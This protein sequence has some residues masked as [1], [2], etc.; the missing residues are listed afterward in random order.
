[1][2]LGRIQPG[3]DAVPARTQAL[4]LIGRLGV[5]VVIA[6]ATND[7]G[8]IDLGPAGAIRVIRNPTF[9][10]VR[11]GG[12]GSGRW[13]LV[14]GRWVDRNPF[15]SIDLPPTSIDPVKRRRDTAPGC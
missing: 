13:S 5:A 10:V 2:K 1:M 3:D 14:D 11:V 9:V 12:H 15:R 6:A 4:R 8:P 7:A